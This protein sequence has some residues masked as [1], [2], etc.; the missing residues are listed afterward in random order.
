MLAESVAMPRLSTFRTL[1][2]SLESKKCNA[3]LIEEGYDSIYI[4]LHKRYTTNHFVYRKSIVRPRIASIKGLA[5]IYSFY[6]I[7]RGNL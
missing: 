4:T 3:K 6:K 1:Q 5:I 2:S 7:K